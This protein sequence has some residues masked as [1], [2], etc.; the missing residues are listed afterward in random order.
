MNSYHFS[1]DYTDFFDYHNNLQRWHVAANDFVDNCF[2]LLTS[3]FNVHRSTAYSVANTLHTRMSDKRLTYHTPVHVLSI[4]QELNELNRKEVAE[5][6]LEAENPLYHL[7]FWFH[8]AVYVPG[9][10]HGDNEADSANFMVSLLRSYL[11]KDDLMQAMQL[12]MV[13]SEYMSEDLEPKYNLMLDL[14]ICNLAWE[15][16]RYDAVAACIKAEFTQTCSE[17][18]YN[19]GRAKFLR[20]MLERKNLFRIESLRNMWEEKARNNMLRSLQILESV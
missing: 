20:T 19:L 10:Q 13:T 9:R 1:Q 2:L 11:P 3:E 14:D 8:D 16:G 5:I 17:E 18:E 15:P 12:I 4:L 7:A 6:R